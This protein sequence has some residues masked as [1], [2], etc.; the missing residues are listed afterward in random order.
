[1]DLGAPTGGGRVEEIRKASHHFSSVKAFAQMNVLAKQI[2]VSLKCKI[3]GLEGF[4]L[5]SVDSGHLASGIGGGRSEG[6]ESWRWWGGWRLHEE[7]G[8]E[9]G[10]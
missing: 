6:R 8:S 2:K 10:I 3:Q 9:I 1:M 4:L 5:R 7:F